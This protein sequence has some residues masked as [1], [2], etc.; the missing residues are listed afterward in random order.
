MA[1]LLLIKENLP[2]T[3]HDLSA[4]KK[5]TRDDSYLK[6]IERLLRQQGYSCLDL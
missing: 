3:Y 1:E 2:K 5:F 4:I 6:E